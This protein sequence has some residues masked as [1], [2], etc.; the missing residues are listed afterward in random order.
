[1]YDFIES[2]RGYILMYDFDFDLI[3]HL[4]SYYFYKKNIIWL[5]V[6]KLLEVFYKSF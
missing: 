4:L 2:P 1:M 3:P 5:F 6:S